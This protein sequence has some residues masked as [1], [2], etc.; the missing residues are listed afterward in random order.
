MKRT[1]KKLQ[2]S[3]ETLQQLTGGPETLRQAR[4]AS[5]PIV[6]FVATTCAPICTANRPCAGYGSERQGGSEAPLARK[7]PAAGARP[8]HAAGP[9]LLARPT[10]SH[11][12]T[13][14]RPASRPLTRDGRSI[15]L[16][17]ISLVK[18][19]VWSPSTSMKPRP[20]SRS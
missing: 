13:R 2:I 3:R 9:H 18:E 15:K 12:T 7:T 19:G 14:N 11:D 10:A 16:S 8:L 6:N 4:G 17:L 20:S 1:S 5:P